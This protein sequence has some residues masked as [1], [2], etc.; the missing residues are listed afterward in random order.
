MADVPTPRQVADLI[1]TAT[2]EHTAEFQKKLQE[3][4]GILGNTPA[5][6]AFV[7]K[8]KDENWKDQNSGDPNHLDVGVMTME[9]AKR[10]GADGH[11]Q[12]EVADVQVGRNA[13]GWRLA[14]N[15]RETDLV[16]KAPDYGS[17]S[18]SEKKTVLTEPLEANN[19]MPFR[20][21][22]ATMAIV[23]GGNFDLT[24]N[25]EKK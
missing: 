17:L 2:P 8:V 21:G 18:D 23:V 25:L 1:K 14:L 13:K 16:Y 19:L 15:A 3:C 24:A 7:A 10:K 22:T 20:S 6:T 5:F 11:D 12:L 9:V 4:A